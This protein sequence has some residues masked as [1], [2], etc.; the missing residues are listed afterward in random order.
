MDSDDISNDFVLVK[1]HHNSYLKNGD[2]CNGN[3]IRVLPKQSK[4]PDSVNLFNNSDTDC[5]D[6]YLFDK[7]T[8]LTQLRPRGS[9]TVSNSY[10][11]THA[12]LAADNIVFLRREI[13]PNDTLQSFALQYNCTVSNEFLSVIILIRFEKKL[14]MYF[15]MFNA[16]FI[17]FKI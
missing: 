10:S 9:V 16:I 8:E 14:K 17:P 6:E 7:T 15:V 11:S 3:S 2:G 1:H 13:L 4:T 12:K 5:N